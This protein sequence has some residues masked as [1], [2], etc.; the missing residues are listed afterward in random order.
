MVRRVCK[1]T[2]D[3]AFRQLAGSLILFL[4]DAHLHA[5][6]DLRSVLAVHFD[7]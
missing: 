7:I 6:F 5:G 3:N 4:N 1:D 2:L